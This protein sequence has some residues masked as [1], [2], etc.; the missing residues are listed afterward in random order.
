VFTTKLAAYT[1]CGA[2]KLPP[3]HRQDDKERNQ[4]SDFGAHGG[5]LRGAGIKQN[6]AHPAKRVGR[7]GVAKIRQNSKLINNDLA[8]KRT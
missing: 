6:D 1:L 3:Q 5:Y 2:A 7:M 8:D 4:G